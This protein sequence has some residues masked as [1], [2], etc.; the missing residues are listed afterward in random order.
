L[1]H[2]AITI[3][4]QHRIMAISTVRPDGWPQTTVVGYVNQGWDITFM[5]FRTGQKFANIQHD[6][7]I[8]IAVA[9][10]PAE[11]SQLQAVYAG[12]HAHEITDETERQEAWR[13]L[14]ER[15]SNLAGFKM[16]D[17]AEAVLMRATC[18]YVSVLDFTQG[19]GHHEELT[20][21]DRGAVIEG[22]QDSDEWSSSVTD[23]AGG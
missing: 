6:D 16:P 18:K 21:D 3:L 14:M 19:P 4:N 10:E 20:I 13:L 5:I 22:R 15:H 2:P 12:A 11:L 1:E 8:S 9:T 7:R 17:A 23:K